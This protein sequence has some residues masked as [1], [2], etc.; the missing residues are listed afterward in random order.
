MATE[1]NYCEG[2]DADRPV[3][4][5]SNDSC[6]KC[7]GITECA[8]CGDL[9]VDKAG[10]MTQCQICTVLE[11]IDK[12]QEMNPDRHIIA[13]IVKCECC[14]ERRVYDPTEIS[15]KCDIC[16]LA[17]WTNHSDCNNGINCRFMDVV[18]QYKD[19]AE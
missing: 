15:T 8:S 6:I 13:P 16:R 10:I 19:I 4:F 5:L 3:N 12:A 18:R 2:C 1:M 9:Y 14:G 17:H 11:Q 7:C